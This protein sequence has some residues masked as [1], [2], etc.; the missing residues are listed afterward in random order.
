MPLSDAIRNIRHWPGKQ[1]R[2]DMYWELVLQCATYVYNLAY[3]CTGN[4][5]D[6]EELVQESLYIALKNFHPLRQKSKFKSWMFA[7]VRSTFLK[8]LRK[9]DHRLETETGSRYLCLSLN[10]M[11]LDLRWQ[12]IQPTQLIVTVIPSK[13]GMKTIRFTLWY[14]LW[15][16]P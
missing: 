3:K 15:H 13:S 14:H 1:R 8:G 12:K 11:T 7:I 5:F 16:Q 2:S 6:A 4:S 9:N 10:Q